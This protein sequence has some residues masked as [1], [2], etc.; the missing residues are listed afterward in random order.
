MRC[1]RASRFHLVRRG[2]GWA[3]TSPC[4]RHT[5]SGLICACSSPQ[6]DIRSHATR[7]R[8]I[9]TRS[10][11]AICPTRPRAY[12][13]VARAFGRAAA[14][15]RGHRFN[16]HKLLLDPYARALAG[17]L[18][19]S[20]ALYG[21]RQ[22]STRGDL[23][24]D[25]RDSAPSMLKCVVTDDSFNWGDDRP[26]AVPWSDTVIYEA[27]TARAHHASQ[28]HPSIAARHF[29]RARASRHDRPP[30]SPRGYRDRADAGAEA[31]LQDRTLRCAAGLTQL[32]GL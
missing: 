23:S 5:R 24:F 14:P 15:E 10:G 1:H 6:G 20:D 32:L 16:H 13:M 18:R 26:L 28:R 11:T 4:S 30:A 29:R 27:H 25:R 8:N 22:H 31:F 2:M 3:S 19:W 9:P 7:C 21:F 12:A 17:H